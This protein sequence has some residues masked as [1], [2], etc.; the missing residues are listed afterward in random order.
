[1]GNVIR[2]SPDVRSVFR[3]LLRK[4]LTVTRITFLFD[5]TRQTVYRWLRRGRHVG[6]ESYKDKP[7]EL[8]TSKVTGIVEL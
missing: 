1:M 2:L 5:T 6:R 3:R 7:R 4:G 8:R